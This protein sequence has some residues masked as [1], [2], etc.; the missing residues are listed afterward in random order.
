MDNLFFPISL[1]DEEAEQ[2]SKISLRHSSAKYI[3]TCCCIFQQKTQIH[4]GNLRE[5]TCNWE[6]QN[7]NSIQFVMGNAI[8]VAAGK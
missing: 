8:Y 4:Q 2:T 6:L 5:K 3:F 7:S 1:G